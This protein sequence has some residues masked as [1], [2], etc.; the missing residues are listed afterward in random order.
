MKELTKA[1]EQLMQY[2]WKM[3]KAFLKDIVAEYPDPKPAYTTV[4]TVVNVL[5]KKGFIAFNTYGKAREYFPSIKKASYTRQTFK[6]ILKNFFNDSPSQ[7]ASF[8]T[9]ENDFSLEELQEMQE[10]IAL[11]IKRQQSK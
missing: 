8:F 9:K 11:K 6:S 5:V 4:S 7:F 10:L 1:E 2:L 3:E